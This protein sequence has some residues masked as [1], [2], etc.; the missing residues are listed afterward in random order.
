MLITTVSK[1]WKLKEKYKQQYIEDIS[2]ILLLLK[3]AILDR[4]SKRI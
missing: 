3:S 4:V 1:S 2:L